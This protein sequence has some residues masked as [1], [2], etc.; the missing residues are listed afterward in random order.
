MNK[1]LKNTILTVA[2]ATALIGAS[3]APLPNTQVADEF[4]LVVQKEQIVGYEDISNDKVKYAF[5]TGDI[6]PVA[7]NEVIEKRKDNEMTVLKSTKTKNIRGEKIKVNEYSTMLFGYPQFIKEEDGQWYDLD[8][9]ETTKDAYEK[10]IG[11]Q[12]VIDLITGYIISDALATSTAYITSGTTWSATTDGSN[13]TVECV[14]GGG[15]GGGGGTNYGSSGGG[16]GEYSSSSVAYTSGSTVSGIQIGQGGGSNISGTETHWNTNVIIAKGGSAGWANG[17]SSGGAGGTGGTGNTKYNGGTGGHSISNTNYYGGGG[18]G[19]AGGKNAHGVDGSDADS[20]GGAYTGHGG[21]GGHGDGTYGGDG[22]SGGVNANGVNG[23]NGTEWSASYGSGGGGGG[24]GGNVV[25][26]GGNG[27]LY[28]A[29]GGG[30]G[31]YDS[32]VGGTGSNGLIVVTYTAPS[33]PAN[34]KS[35]QG[36]VKASVKTINGLGIG[37][38]KI[39]NGLN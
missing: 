15:G 19:G 23:S 5:K 27:G 28:G 10:Q 31:T 13:I 26:S 4:K 37:N 18:G 39:D 21:D 1:I 16:G 9:A 35:W 24:G 36:L 34:L 12:K 30:S 33:G 3:Q 17:N 7:E 14:G 25:G 32:S 11:P 20:S 38:V 6:V 29:G 22:G 8:Y 2:G